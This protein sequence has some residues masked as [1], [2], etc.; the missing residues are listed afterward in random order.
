[1]TIRRFIVVLT[2]AVA[3]SRMTGTFADVVGIISDWQLYRH[4]ERYFTQWTLLH[5]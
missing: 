3:G 4:I 2:N 1:M 5:N